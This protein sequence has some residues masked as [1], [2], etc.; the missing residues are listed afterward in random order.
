MSDGKVIEVEGKITTVLPGTMF[1]VQLDN[2]HMVL[3]HISGKL[4]KHF[5]K[6]H[7]ASGWTKVTA[8]QL[9]AWLHW[10]SDEKF[11]AASQARKLS[12]VR[13]LCRYLVRERIR[14]DDP[15]ELL[16]GPKLRR[17]LPETLSKPE[18]E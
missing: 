16:A 1:R 3:A 10:L 6:Q 13:M 12:A 15:T 5:I 14:P 7:G 17:K 2:G 11:S 18:M 9:A 8:R 4:R